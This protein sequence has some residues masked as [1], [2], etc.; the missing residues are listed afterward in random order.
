MKVYIVIKK[1]VLPVVHKV[2][3]T[4]EKAKE[5]IRP[6]EKL[7]KDYIDLMSNAKGYDFIRF[8]YLHQ[9]LFFEVSKYDTTYKY[10]DVLNV[11]F[12]PRYKIILKEVE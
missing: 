6:L 8:H 7:Y 5:Y 2:F 11:K 1:E 4:E 10:K 3:D 12:F 9:C